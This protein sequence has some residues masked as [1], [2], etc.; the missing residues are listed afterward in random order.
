MCYY[1]FIRSCSFHRSS[2]NIE[3]MFLLDHLFT[4]HFARLTLVYS[5]CFLCWVTPKQY[6][7][8][9]Y[10]LVLS[11]SKH[12]I[13]TQTCQQRGKFGSSVRFVYAYRGHPRVCWSP[14]PLELVR[15]LYRPR[16]GLSYQTIWLLKPL[17]PQNRLVM[18][19]PRDL[20]AI[21]HSISLGRCIAFFY[22][23]NPS[24]RI[25]EWVSE[26]TNIRICEYV[27]WWYL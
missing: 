5:P 18:M 13:Q 15:R 27:D 22:S 3:L 26:C 7:R 19:H 14:P 10:T 12:F 25:C 4:A 17:E 9:E 20:K 8:I 11:L 21:R 6:L 16:D 23:P 24:V 1:I 2:G